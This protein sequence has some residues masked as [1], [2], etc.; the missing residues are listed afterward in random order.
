MDAR[1]STVVA[2]HP[3]GPGSP[4]Y[5]R[6]LGLILWV[7]ATLFAI[8]G[9]VIATATL[10][11][12][13][14]EPG[15]LRGSVGVYAF[16]WATIG[17]RIAQ[18]H[19]RNAVGWLMLAA[20][21]GFGIIAVTQEFVIAALLGPSPLHNAEVTVRFVRI[22]GFLTSL[23]AGLTVLVFPDGHLPSRRWVVVGALVVGLNL[24]GAAIAATAPLPPLAGRANP[25]L[26]AE[27]AYFA[28]LLYPLARYGGPLALVACGGA[29]LARV[30]RANDTEREQLKWVVAGG[31]IAL[32]TN[33]VANALPA[34]EV[35]QII[36][37]VTLLAI[38]LSI[39]IA[40]AYYHL[41]DIDTILNRTLV[42]VILT[43]FLAGLTAALLGTIQRVFIA[44]TGQSSDAA[45]VITTV[46]LVALLGSVRDAV[47]G[48]IDRRFKGAATGLTGLRTFAANVRQY[49][50]LSD[51]QRLLMRL[52]SESVTGLGAAGGAAEVAVTD[53]PMSIR[54]V[55][56]WD[57][58]SRVTT[59]IKA[60]NGMT[61][62]IR[63]GPRSNG[64]A[65]SKQQIAQLRDAA[66]AVAEVLA[67]QPSGA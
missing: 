42:Y 56:E 32:I 44:I 8:G 3:V 24:L 21:V 46:I 43:A 14:P 27:R 51:A 40:M 62:W 19:P 5:A 9:I 38:P 6:R 28:V 58:D 36:Q 33:L 67:E 37:L 16:A 2:P 48:F 64:E 55:G 66:D 29:L 7:I 4:T 1:I 61:A 49:A 45:I 25:F 20:G 39:G 63:L 31:G 60:G 15:Y 59:T 23:A 65:Y 12:P 54:T 11:T 35:L 10:S 13:A 53:R 50:G 22:S 52:L 34:I 30:R 41:Y 18:R 17:L 47:Q 57:G 26:D